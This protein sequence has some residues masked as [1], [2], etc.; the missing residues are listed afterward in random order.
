MPGGQITNTFCSFI[1]PKVENFVGFVH[2]IT[3]N[4]VWLS[5]GSWKVDFRFVTL[6][7]WLCTW[8]CRETFVIATADV[9]GA[10]SID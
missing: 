4:D 3:I 9:R 10:P 7:Q 5:P 1:L 6:D 8:K 2:V